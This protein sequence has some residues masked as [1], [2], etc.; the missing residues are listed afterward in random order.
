[1]EMNN[2]CKECNKPPTPE[3][4]DACL[5]TLV[6]VMNA[7]CGH[8]GLRSPYVQFWDSSILYGESAMIVINELKKFPERPV[9]DGVTFNFVQDLKNENDQLKLRYKSMKKVDDPDYL[10][11]TLR[12]ELH[13]IK[14]NI[15]LM[16]GKSGGPMIAINVTISNT[17]EENL[18]RVESMLKIIPKEDF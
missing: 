14:N 12:A 10:I 13:A 9:E 8:G 1:M 11:K 18:R 15:N 7:C 16:L 6:G 3:D 2:P 17:I 5:G 4:H